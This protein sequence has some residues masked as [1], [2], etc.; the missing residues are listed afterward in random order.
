MKGFPSWPVTGIMYM[1]SDK[2]NKEENY[3]VLW[4]WDKWAVFLFLERLY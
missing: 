3:V 4:H 2:V 1:G